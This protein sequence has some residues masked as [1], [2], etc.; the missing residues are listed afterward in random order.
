MKYLILF[1]VSFNVAAQSD[2]WKDHK[3]RSDSL[4]QEHEKQSEILRKFYE[5]DFNEAKKGVNLEK[6][7]LDPNKAKVNKYSSVLSDRQRVIQEVNKYRGIPY[8]WGGS[9][10]TAFDC[11]GLVQWT[12][13]KTHGKTIPRTT[14][15]QYKSWER[16]MKRNIADA[17]PGDFV[18][19]K[20][21]NNGSPVSH[22]GIYVGDNKFIHAPKS[23]DVVK[24]S[25][26]KG[27]WKEKFVGYVP[28]KEILKK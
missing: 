27:Y 18:Y 11:S 5:A 6:V 23:N 9:N 25:E 20:T 8:L 13:K 7:K 24:E 1:L 14:A 2:L 15:T 4:W 19:F 21:Q 22:V 10:P 16:S 28:L 3:K 17:D 26:L 12:I